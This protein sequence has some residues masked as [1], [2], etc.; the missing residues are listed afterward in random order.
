MLYI[1]PLLGL[2]VLLIAVP[3]VFAVP[4]IQRRINTLVRPNFGRFLTEAAEKT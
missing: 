2:V 3:Q 1:E 4:L